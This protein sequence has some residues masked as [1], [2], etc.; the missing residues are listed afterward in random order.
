MT[1]ESWTAHFSAT[2]RRRPGHR[3]AKSVR[4]GR[5]ALDLDELVRVPEHG[6]PEQ[7]ARGPMWLQ[8][9]RHNIPDSDEVLAIPDDIHRRLHQVRRSGAMATQDSKQVLDR[10]LGL[11]AVVPGSHDVPISIK[12][13]RT[14]GEQRR[15]TARDG[16]VTVGNLCEAFV[17]HEHIV[18]GTAATR[19]DRPG[20]SG[21]RR[22]IGP[23]CLPE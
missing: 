4:K 21:V 16:G 20:Q 14:C 23:S 7:G 18:A 13:A 17:V 3:G 6:N 8:T 5:D 22:F 10:L 15:T 1:R 11:G 9:G 12:R 2:S 19:A